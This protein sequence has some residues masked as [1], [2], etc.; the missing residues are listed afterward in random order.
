M[1]AIPQAA[2][3]D[4]DSSE[5][6]RGILHY[7][8]STDDASSP[9][10][11]GY[12]FVDGCVDETNL[13]PTISNTAGTSFYMDTEAVTV[14]YNSANVFKWYLNDVSLFVEWENP[15]LL[16]IMNGQSN[17][18]TDSHT[19]EAP[20]ANEWQYIVI[21]TAFAVAHPIHLHVSPMHPSH[22]TLGT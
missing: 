16:Q 5:N 14:G 11:T 13:V 1:R 8:T 15:T 20:N 22:P 21:Q 19:L 9:T 17:W 6:I 2:C 4:N 12:D 7:G 18:T 10:T 3:S